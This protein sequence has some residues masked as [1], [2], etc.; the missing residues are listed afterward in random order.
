MSC[1]NIPSVSD[2]EKTKLRVDHF[3]ELIDGTPSGTS[4]NPVTGKVLPTYE[5]VISGLGFKHGSGDFTT[6]F[7]VMPGERDIAWYDPVSLNWYSYLGVIPSSG[8]VVSPVTDP[9]GDPDWKPV[10]DQLLRDDLSDMDGFSYIGSA[11]YTDVR[12]YAGDADTIN[13]YGRSNI[14]DCAHGTFILDSTDSTSPD[15]DGITLVDALGRRWKRTFTGSFFASWFGVKADGTTNDRLSIKNTVNVVNQMGGGKIEFPNGDCLISGSD[16]NIPVK[17]IDGTLQYVDSTLEVQMYFANLNNIEFYFNGGRFLSD[18]TDGG[19]TIAFDGGS[20]ITLTRPRTRGATVMSGS[21]VT[22]TG[23][24]AITLLSRSGNLDGVTIIDPEIDKHY[25]S[26]DISGDPASLFRVSNVVINGVP[27]L[28][29]GYYGLA[30]RGNGY[31]VRMHN[32]YSNKLNRPFF[33]YD[34][35]DVSIQIIGDEMNGGFQSL[36]KAYTTNTVNIDVDFSV[37]G[38]ANVANCLGLQSQHNPAL[39]PTPAYL[40]NIKIKYTDQNSVVGESIRFDYYRDAVATATSSSLLFTEIELNGA[41]SGDVYSSVS[42]TNNSNQCVLHMEDFACNNGKAIFGGG[43]GFVPS[44]VGNWTP[45]DGSG[46][47]L[48]MDNPVGKYVVG[49]VVVG[50]F[51]LAYPVTAN[52]SAAKISGLPVRAI[53]LS[54]N[55]QSLSISYTDVGFDIYGLI[56][57]GGTTVTFYKNTGVAVTNAELSGKH[58]RGSFSYIA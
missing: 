2:L 5:K 38:R 40:K 20:N 6:G 30:C 48:V 56:E 33:V 31:N 17:E 4:T 1:E 26:I 22:T 51:S 36:I 42:L 18:K 43:S 21:T 27:K 7:T 23:T 34:T 3:G 12:M 16:G 47:G 37:R 19:T 11:S 24:S 50:T 10:T 45:T 13:V 39:Q 58:L 54:S 52:G 9:V 55:S 15:N 8:Y 49:N 28:T 41:A 35:T 57:Q 44:A 14:F 25:A 53:P 29:N 32:A 46:A